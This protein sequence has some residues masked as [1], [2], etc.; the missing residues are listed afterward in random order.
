MSNTLKTSKSLVLTA[1]LLALLSSPAP[2]MAA[3]APV[4]L[5]SAG[6]F[7]ILS[8]AGITDVSTSS[9]VGDIG[10]SP[11]TGAAITATDGNICD[12][13][14]GTI[15]TVD[16]TGP[17]CRVVDATLLGAAVLDMGTAYTDAAGRAPTGTNYIEV[18]A[19]NISGMTLAPGVYKWSTSVVINSN[20]TLSGGPNDVWIFQVAG[21]LNIASDGSVPAGIKV[22][23]SGGARAA[24][25]FWQVAGATTLGTYS[26]FNG[27]ILDK[28]NIALQTHAVLNGRALAQTAVTLQMN[29]IT[30]T[31]TK[32]ECAE[33]LKADKKGFDDGQKAD[34]QAFDVLQKA[35]KQAFDDGQKAA[36]QAFLATTPPPT[37]AQKK[38]FD[39]GQKAKDQAFDDGQKAKDQ[40]FDVLQKA[41]KQSFDAQQKIDKQECNKL[42]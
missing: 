21:N 15:Y 38:V 24:N 33:L 22:I 37:S 19:G 32:K 18:G 35:D 41:D 12:E 16:A 14:T 5:G 10:T 30:T 11:I 8:K 25:V 42:Q 27:T 1:A 17:A 3:T 9:I 4:D 36:K 29:A 26:T 34:K 7:V 39:D 2:G 6:S 28:A 23:L 13:V 31:E 40:A 20:V